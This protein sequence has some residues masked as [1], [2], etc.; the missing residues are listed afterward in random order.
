MQVLDFVR[1]LQSLQ[2]FTNLYKKDLYPPLESPTIYLHHATRNTGDGP[3]T[4]G[5]TTG[6]HGNGFPAS[7]NTGSAQ[8]GNDGPPAMMAKPNPLTMWTRT[9]DSTRGPTQP[10]G[11]HGYWS[12]RHLTTGPQERGPPLDRG[13]WMSLPNRDQRFVLL[14]TYE[15]KRW[16][17]SADRHAWQTLRARLHARVRWF[18]PAQFL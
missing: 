10:T 6:E 15:S 3:P 8:R 2:I 1:S 9:R 5:T 14:L 11:Q 13:G 12:E 18:R 16:G 17:D 7:R 4:R